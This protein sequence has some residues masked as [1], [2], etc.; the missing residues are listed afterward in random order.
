MRSVGLDLG[1]KEVSFC[2]VR[3]GKVVVRRTARD[4]GQLDQLG[5]D[6]PPANVAIEACREAWHVHDLLTANGHNVLLI[7]T[8]R[9]KRLGIGQHGRKNDRIDA[10]VIA[11]AVEE[12]RIPQAHMLSRERRLL[13]EKLNVRRALIETRASIITTIRGVVRARG[14]KLAPSDTDYFRRNLA[15][16]TLT[17]ATRATLAPLSATLGTLDEQLSLL[18][19][20]LEALGAQEPIVATLTTAPGISLVVAAAFVSVIDSAKRFTDAH[21]VASY[22]GLVPREKTSGGSD[23]RKLGAITKCGNPYLRSMLVQAAWCILRRR[24]QEDPLA[25][26]GRQV[27]ERR[28]KR[29]AVVAL[30]RRLAGVLWAMWRDGLPYEMGRVASASARG[31]ERAALSAK[32]QAEAMRV[33]AQKANVRAGRIRARLVKEVSA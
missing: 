8:T 18:E 31:T 2:E 30:A 16:A 23:N 22:I 25:A 24:C 1:K 32:E 20:E 13:R 7:D 5:P 21:K 33:I 26:W 11:R 29:I 19:P 9:V 6:T 27:A 28:G 14:E 10:E 15:K 3:D 12:N 4:V 17:D